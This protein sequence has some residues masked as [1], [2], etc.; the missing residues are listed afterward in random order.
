[1][2]RYK[3]FILNFNTKLDPINKIKSD[4][5]V[6][7]GLLR[8]KQ[9]SKLFLWLPIGYALFGFNRLFSID[10]FN[11]SCFAATYFQKFRMINII[12]PKVSNQ[13]LLPYLHILNVRYLNN[14]YDNQTSQFSEIIKCLTVYIGLLNTVI[15]V[16]LSFY[17]FHGDL[18]QN[19]SGIKAILFYISLVEIPL[20]WLL[21]P[22]LF[23]YLIKRFISKYIIKL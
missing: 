14:I 17:F 13:P 21:V 1:L 22:I 8:Q 5:Q 11:G 6:L 20:V 19:P 16:P 7:R 2:Q 23:N 18:L 3:D 4:L 10:S 9:F 15:Y 12:S